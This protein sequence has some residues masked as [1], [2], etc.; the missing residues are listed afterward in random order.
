MIICYI[1][2]NKIKDFYC[3][4]LFIFLVVQEHNHNIMC[5]CETLIFITKF[6]CTNSP[7]QHCNSLPV[8]H[9][10]HIHVVVGKWVVE[11]ESV[12]SGEKT[13]TNP[14]MVAS[15]FTGE[16]ELNTQS[17][18]SGCHYFHGARAFT[19][20]VIA[21]FTRA[22]CDSLSWATCIHTIS[23]QPIL[24]LILVASSHMHQE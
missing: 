14:V 2:G 19:C 13:I 10:S 5:L 21:T 9:N 12:Y 24:L 16:C 11:A 22:Y 1:W 18:L 3:F 17:L 4:S 6:C 15:H 8:S 7:L 20:S 23:F